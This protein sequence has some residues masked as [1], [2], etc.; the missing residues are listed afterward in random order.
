M[1]AESFAQLMK[2]RRKETG[3]KMETVAAETAYVTG[4]IGYIFSFRQWRWQAFL[5]SKRMS[6]TSLATIEAVCENIGI[7]P[8]LALVHL[9]VVKYDGEY[10][11]CLLEPASVINGIGPAKKVSVVIEPDF[12]PAKAE[13]LYEAIKLLTCTKDKLENNILVQLKFRRSA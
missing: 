10:V 8:N 7:D 3:K 1:S 2:A 12:N 13:S 9:G 4:T 5:S 11:N 6:Q